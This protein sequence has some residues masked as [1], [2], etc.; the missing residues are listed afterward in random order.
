MR[1]EEVSPSTRDNENHQNRVVTCQNVAATRQN[2]TAMLESRTR[3]STNP[4]L[5]HVGLRFPSH[6]GECLPFSLPA[7]KPCQHRVATLTCT[8]L[9]YELPTRGYL[10]YTH[11]YR[12]LSSYSPSRTRPCHLA[13]SP[14][15]RLACRRTD[16]VTL[17]PFT[18]LLVLSAENILERAFPFA[19]CQSR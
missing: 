4:C 3:S 18:R 14:R 15:L 12:W 17:E 16:S 8:A 5:L 9:G 1:P 11:P 7:A 13:F 10:I 19:N 2:I 6:R